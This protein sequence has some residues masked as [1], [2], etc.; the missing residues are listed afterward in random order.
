SENVK[1]GM[2]RAMREGRYV[3]KPPKGYDVGY[4]ADGRYLIQPND[5]APHIR[6]AFRLAADTDLPVAAIVRHLQAR[7][8]ACSK[9]QLGLLLRNPLYA[10]RIVVPAWRG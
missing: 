5:D 8:F 9:N 2:R 4:D 7:G 6:E 1:R 10:G 3:N